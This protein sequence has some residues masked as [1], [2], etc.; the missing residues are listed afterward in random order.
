MPGTGPAGIGIAEE[1][2]AELLALF[3]ATSL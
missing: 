2:E 1:R 3:G